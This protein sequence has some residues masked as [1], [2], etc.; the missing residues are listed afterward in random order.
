MALY[1]NNVFRKYIKKEKKNVEA[2]YSKEV[3]DSVKKMLYIQH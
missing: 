1:F 3:N 2:N